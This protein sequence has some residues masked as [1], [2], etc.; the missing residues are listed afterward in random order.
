MRVTHRNQVLLFL[1]NRKGHHFRDTRDKRRNCVEL[2]AKELGI[3]R[4]SVTS[5][6]LGLR[7]NG[8]IE[9]DTGTPN[10]KTTVAVWL[11]E[12]GIERAQRVAKAALSTPKRERVRKPEK[13]KTK[14]PLLN[15]H[16]EVS[17]VGALLRDDGG[18]EYILS[19]GGGRVLVA[20]VTHE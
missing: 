3:E 20:E 2:I 10:G 11:T 13:P 6:L 19:H 8:L 14:Q 17:V 16:D 12:E 7:E 1:Y 15:L 9:R 4:K 5:A 18:Y